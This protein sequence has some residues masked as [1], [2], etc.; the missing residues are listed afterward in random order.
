MRKTK[1]NEGLIIIRRRVSFVDLLISLP[2]TIVI[3]FFRLKDLSIL[4]S[5]SLKDLR[6]DP[7][8]IFIK[9]NY[10]ILIYN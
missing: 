5:F 3:R 8:F 10:F 7:K 1:L 2:F 6:I 4:S 9:I